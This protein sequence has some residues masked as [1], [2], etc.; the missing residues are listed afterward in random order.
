MERFNQNGFSLIEFIVTLVL[1][2]IV[3]AMVVSFMGTKVTQSG[4][5]VTWMRDTFELSAVMERMLADYREELKKEHPDFVT[6]FENRDTASEIN[7]PTMYGPDIDIDEANADPIAFD[8]DNKEIP[9]TE[10]S[11]IWKVTLKKGDQTLVTLFTE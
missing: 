4:R 1:V 5:S 10:A 8:E 3:G 6:F 11:T 2:A 7:A 9:A